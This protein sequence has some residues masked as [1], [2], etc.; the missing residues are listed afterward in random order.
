MGK[1]VVGRAVVVEQEEVVS[2]ARMPV[3][4]DRYISRAGYEHLQT[5]LPGLRQQI[6]AARREVEELAQGSKKEVDARRAVID[7]MVKLEAAERDII[8][9]LP[10]ALIIED[11]DRP[12]EGIWFGDA[13][14]YADDFGDGFVVL[15]NSREKE[16]R[17]HVVDLCRQH[18]E[19]TCDHVDVASCESPLIQALLGQKAGDIVEFMVRGQAQHAKILAV[20]PLLAR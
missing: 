13:V 17:G 19:M 15:L 14:S 4:Y 6:E 1:T 9:F 3:D 8:L 12:V 5:K 10:S 20:T 7:R 2:S 18:V 11:Q 16:N